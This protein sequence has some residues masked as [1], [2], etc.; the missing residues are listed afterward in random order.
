MPTLEARVGQLEEKL[1]TNCSPMVLI[2]RAM[3]GVDDTKTGPERQVRYEPI[4][5]KSMRDGGR[6]WPR[7][8]GEKVEAMTERVKAELQAEGHKVYSVCEEYAR[9]LSTVAAYR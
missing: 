7:M 8:P 2:I 9:D 4:G 3:V 6:S 1:G 5:L